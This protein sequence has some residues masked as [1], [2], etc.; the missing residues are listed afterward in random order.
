MESKCPSLQQSCTPPPCGIPKLSKDRWNIPNPNPSPKSDKKTWRMSLTPL[1]ETRFGLVRQ[2]SP[3]LSHYP[4][5]MTIYEGSNM[6]RRANW[7]TQLPTTILCKAALVLTLHQSPTISCFTSPSFHRA[8]QHFPAEIHGLR[9]GGAD[10]H[11]LHIRLQM[12]P[13]T[14]KATVGWSQQNHIICRETISKSLKLDIPQP[15]MY[16]AISPVAT[17][18][19]ITV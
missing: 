14:L 15:K 13:S 11:P 4:I 12:A 2:K 19:T 5:L 10:L 17:A 16:T 6:D 3:S 9:L 7:K 1:E 18:H 8:I